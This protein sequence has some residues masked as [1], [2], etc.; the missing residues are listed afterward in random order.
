MR[1]ARAHALLQGNGFVTPDDVK[2]VAPAA[3]RHR[4][5]LATDLE[6]EGYSPDDVLADILA[7]VDAPRI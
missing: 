3:L 6:I 2:A 4:L 5:K 7:N 1:A